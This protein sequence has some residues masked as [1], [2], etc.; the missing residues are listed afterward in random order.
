MSGDDIIIIMVMI[1]SFLYA[2][3]L[4]S[5]LSDIISFRL[6]R[7]LLS[8][9]ALHKLNDAT[10]LKIIHFLQY[11]RNNNLHQ[12][13]SQQ[14]QSWLFVS[15]HP[16]Y[17]P[18]YPNPPPPQS[19]HAPSPLALTAPKAPRTMTVSSKHSPTSVP[20]PSSARP[21]PR[22]APRPCK[23]ALTEDSKLSNLH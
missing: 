4:K 22:H 9:C 11:S 1:G 5:R 23:H 7:L 16:V 8:P 17:L 18:P 2:L 15:Q 19:P 12:I 3:K 14:Q 20:V 6:Y 21:L 13:S 10:T